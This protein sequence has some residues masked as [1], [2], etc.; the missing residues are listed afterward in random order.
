MAA[1]RDGLRPMAPPGR[2]KALPTPSGPSPPAPA[3]PAALPPDGAPGGVEFVMSPELELCEVGSRE[4]RRGGF[5]RTEL[6]WR[7]PGW[8]LSR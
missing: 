2:G 5:C 3:A 4:S 6:A 1:L 8:I 7:E